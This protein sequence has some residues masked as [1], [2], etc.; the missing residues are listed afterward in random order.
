MCDPGHDRI[1]HRVSPAAVGGAFRTALRLV[2]NR[3]A[4]GVFTSKVG[5]YT[6]P[7]LQYLLQYTRTRTSRTSL[8]PLGV[9]L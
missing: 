4:I 1:L 7:S 6:V 9:R 8:G 2:A 3:P 5:T